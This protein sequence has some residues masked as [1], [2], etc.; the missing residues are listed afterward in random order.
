MRNLSILAY[1]TI[2][3][4]HTTSKSFL[5]Q[6]EPQVVLGKSTAVDRA[7]MGHAL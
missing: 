2:N 7:L 3:V 6:K 4:S 5:K 1:F